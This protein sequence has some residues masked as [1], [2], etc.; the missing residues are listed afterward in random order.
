MTEMSEAR[1]IH[2]SW[3]AE[4]IQDKVQRCKFK[5]WNKLKRIFG[6]VFVYVQA[7]NNISMPDR[8][9]HLVTKYL[10]PSDIRGGIIYM[11]R[12][13]QAV[14]FKDD[15]K[16]IGLKWPL[17]N[18]SLVKSLSPFID[19]Q[20]ILRVGGRLAKAE[21]LS[22]EEK[23]PIILP[24]HHKLTKAIFFWMHNAQPYAPR[25]ATSVVGKH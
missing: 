17:L 18:N 14:Q 11:I 4:V 10:T 9:N 22:F 8:L 19:N 7:S 3:V 16:R 15:I 23:H 5:D 12:A 21:H 24:A 2:F 6:Y 20:G 25:W 1:P 13:V